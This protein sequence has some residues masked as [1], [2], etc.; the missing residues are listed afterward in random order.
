MHLGLSAARV[1]F[2]YDHLLRRLGGPGYLDRDREALVFRERRLRYGDLHD[3]AARLA[4]A[5]VQDGVG[6]GDRVAILLRNDPVW[7]D[8]FFAVAAARAVLVPVNY[9]L[10]PNEVSFILND[11]GATTLVVGDDLAAT[12]HEA[13]IEAPRCR[14]L[15][16]VANAG[17]DTGPGAAALRG[18]HEI[19]AFAARGRIAWPDVGVAPDDPNLLQYTSGTTGFPKGATHTVST[20]LWNSFHQIADFRI[21][22]RERYLCVPALCWAAGLHDFTLATLWMGGTVVLNPSGGVTIAKLLAAIERERVTSVLL[23]PTLL[24]QLVESPY[25][26]GHD[27][28][29]L[30]AVLTGAEPVPVSVIRRFNEVLRDT[31]LIQVYGM[32]EGPTVATYLR[33]EDAIRKV[34]SCGKPV[35]NCELRVVDEDDRDVAPGQPGEVLTRSAATMVGYWNRPEASAETLRGGWLHTGDLGVLDEEGF[36][37]IC[38]R[39]KDMFIS[40]GLNVYPAEIEAVL[41][42]EAGVA[43]CAVFGVPDERWGEVGHALVVAKP[44]ARVDPDALRERCRAVLGSYKVPARIELSLEPLPRT[45]SGKVQKFK[46]R[47]A[48][49][50]RSSAD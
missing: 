30:V 47:E 45:A 5:L 43:E 49:A 38:G 24:K 16:V 13:L 36:L 3:G 8:V 12:A 29:S 21:T 4:D 41:L 9:L 33:V 15:L 35:T 34:G 10:R 23:V 27:L 2:G 20:L 40:G 44:E 39:K 32:S 14:R 46:L 6:H 42:A 37:S 25:L 48:A 11:S 17:G 1:S 18:A 26:K 50:G 31:T 19:G 22:E 7:L 28:S